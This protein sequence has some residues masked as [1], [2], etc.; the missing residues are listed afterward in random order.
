MKIGILVPVW[1]D[2]GWIAPI[3]L[4]AIRKHWPSHPELWF[5]GLV[6]DQ[7]EGL[8]VIPLDPSVDRANWTDD[9]S[10]GVR[11]MR[12]RGFDAIYL[13]AEEHIPL[14]ECHE[15]HLNRTIPSLMEEL[16]ASYISLMGWDNR[17]FT[18]K[19]PL[20]GMSDFK[21]KHLTARGDPRF[22]LH[23]A[24]WRSEV[25]ERCC[26]LASE[27]KTKKGS[28]WHF[29]KACGKSSSGL[30]P[31]VESGCYQICS[32]CLALRPP[33]R[34]LEMCR[35][36]QRFTFHKL[37]ALY[38]LISNPKFAKIYW[39]SVQFDNVFCDGPYPMFFS[40]IMAKGGLNRFF[41]KFVRKH[42]PKLLKKI[43]N[44]IPCR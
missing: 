18:S 32:S 12:E 30:S 10:Q 2:Y 8:P 27:D 44:S 22:H 40:G 28:A 1:R 9:L 11:G 14:S 19:S 25:L 3:A 35:F 39:E 43:F 20:L 26:A 5:C 17:R 13:I 6:G 41:V 21:L 4:E 37:M 31:A 42:D 33:S 15:V 7:S 23:P 38:P 16:S 24:L 29:E 36:F 34:I